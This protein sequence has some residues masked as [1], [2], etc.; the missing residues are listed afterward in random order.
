MS[1]QSTTNRHQPSL[2][3]KETADILLSSNFLEAVPDAIVAVDSD[4]TIVQINSQT[5]E[6]FGYTR[7]DL[8]GQ[9][10]EVLVPERHRPGHDEHRRGFGHAPK[11]RRMGAGLELFGRRR[12]GSEF[13][14]EIM[15]SPVSIGNGNLVLSA[16]R[17]ISDQK[18]IEQ[19]LRRANEEL[20]RR[21]AQQI[22]EYRARLASIIDSA[23]DAIIR[24]LSMA[25]SPAGT[26]G[27]KEFTAIA[28]RKCSA[29]ILPC[30]R[31]K[32]GLTKSR[33]FLNEFG[34]GRA[35][36]ISNPCV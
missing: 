13:P 16:I 27:R 29:R 11:V 5:E 32:I 34:A 18:K 35:S 26:K 23:E 22:G 1:A 2:S 24:R 12:D 17:D 9:K 36:S 21:S 4:G 3:A 8:L 20:D 14:V 10:V 28:A 15:L 6:L 7:D 25:P 30:W 33:K 19:E 31:R